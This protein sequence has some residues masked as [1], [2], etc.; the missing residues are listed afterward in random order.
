MPVDDKTRDRLKK[1]AAM[2]SSPYPAE[3]ETARRLLAEGLQKAGITE[4]Q[5]F[6]WTDKG[7]NVYRQKT[8][9]WE[10]PRRNAAREDPDRCPQCLWRLG[11]A[12]DCDR[13]PDFYNT[14]P[15]H[16]PA[17]CLLCRQREE[18]AKA[19]RSARADELRDYRSGTMATSYREKNYRMN[20]KG[21]WVEE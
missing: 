17:T 14:R 19:T 2:R 5:L 15:F 21:E 20:E 13:N 9:A 8:E 1:I 11:H 12:P 3:A 7:G 4:A 6:D 10:P 18:A 16:D